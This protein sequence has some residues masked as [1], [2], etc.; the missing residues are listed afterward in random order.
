[1]WKK[2][3]VE[4]EKSRDRKH[5]CIPPAS[6]LD[7]LVLVRPKISVGSEPVRGA[8]QCVHLLFLQLN[9]SRAVSID[10]LTRIYPCRLLGMCF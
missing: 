3:V 8:Y 1:M 7:R 2:E 4:I 9:D 6:I 10:L 5:M